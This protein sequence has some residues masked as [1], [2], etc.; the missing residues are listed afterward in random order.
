MD[1]LWLNAPWPAVRVRRGPG[2][3]RAQANEAACGWA[4]QHGLQPQQLTDWAAALPL[5]GA[6]AA[7]NQGPWP[8]ASAWLRGTGV[9]LPDGVLWWLQAADAPAA[10][11]GATALPPLP[12]EPP[13]GL[14]L[15]GPLP[16]HDKA[17]ALAE[18][19]RLAAQALGVGFWIRDEASG[20]A[21]WDEQMY[22]IYGLDPA[23]GPP[24]VADWLQRCVH[25]QDHAR[26]ATQ[27]MQLEAAARRTDVLIEA[28]FRILDA[29][30]R[31]RWVQS[32][33]Q[34]ARAEGRRISYGMHMDVSER[35]WADQRAEHERLRAQLAIDAAG[36]GVWE[37]DAQGRLTYWSDTMYRLRGLSSDDP[38][39]VEQIIADS[40][41]PHE[42]Q[43]LTEL[44]T[45]HL[46]RGLPFRTEFRVRW[47]DGQQRWLATEGRALRGPQGQL[48]G[49]AG[50][51]H[52]VTERRLAEALQQDKQRLEQAGRDQSAFM[53]RMSHDLRTPMN[54]VLGFTRLLQDDPHEPPSPRQRERLAHIGNEGQRLMRLIDDLLQI[55]KG[56]S[57]PALQPAGDALRVLCVEDNPVNLQLV[58]ELLAMRPGVQLRTA[59]TGHEGLQAALA[60]PPDLLLLDLQ[61]PDLPGLA[62]MR[63]LRAQPALAGC[64]IV[65]LSADAMPEHI[66]AGLA[67]GFDDYWTKPIQ[68]DHFLAG[69]DERARQMALLR[70]GAP[71]TAP[72]AP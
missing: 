72:G 58:R 14:D 35:Q 19:G 26:I 31:E 50:V 41:D 8:L 56:G 69:I 11:A 46:A 16:E 2:P 40:L 39:P 51:N 67:A 25:P 3:A 12:A 29:Q 49:M 7:G 23:L 71:A 18:R 68:F 4:R 48:L 38:R 22:R 43:R 63:A 15:T 37:R 62:V 44:R 21:H 64:R 47:P 9:A 66:Q 60:E 20:A 6:A 34:R 61:L 45:D 59:E 27:A 33:T 13:P 5:D 17:H 52:D 36:V 10:A 55:A 65:A 32:W 30:R 54:A 57:V 1:I 53:A 28:T 42:R 24:A 70:A